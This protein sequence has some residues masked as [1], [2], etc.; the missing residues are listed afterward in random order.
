MLRN[1]FKWLIDAWIVPRGMFRAA[2]GERSRVHRVARGSRIAMPPRW[3]LRHSPWSSRAPRRRGAGVQSVSQGLGAARRAH[4]SRRIRARGRGPGASGRS[5]LQRARI[6]V[7]SASSK[8]TTALRTS[9]RSSPAMPT[10]CRQVFRMRRSGLSPT[11]AARAIRDRW[12]RAMRRCS[13]GL[14]DNGGHASHHPRHARGLSRASSKNTTPRFPRSSC[15]GRRRRGTACPASRSR[16]SSRSATCATS[17]SRA[18]SCVS[19]ARWKRRRHCC[20]RSTA[21]PWRS[22]ATTAARMPRRCSPRFRAARATTLA[23]LR[24]L[25][26]CSC[27]RP[28]VFEGY[29]PVTLRGLVHYLCSHDQ[30]HLSGLQWLLGKID[31]AGMRA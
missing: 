8:S 13:T 29:G 6:F 18:T 28:A 27:E 2:T 17:R 3:R 24:G 20:R 23:L 19:G 21:R 1:V 9:A 10:T 30:Q 16:P 11:G 22:S 4:R 12:V 26:A 14:V 25:D 31:A 5:R 15:T 7:G